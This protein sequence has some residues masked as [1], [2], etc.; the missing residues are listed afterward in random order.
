MK[1][2]DIKENH[3]QY[4]CKCG[5]SICYTEFKVKGDY[6]ELNLCFGL[7]SGIPVVQCPNCKH[8]K[9]VKLSRIKKLKPK[10]S[11]IV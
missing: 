9:V 2:Y 4:Y 8:F 10:K 11:T 5:C 7:G 1:Y 3:Q 6:K